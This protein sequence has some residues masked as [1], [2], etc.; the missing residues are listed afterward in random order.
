FI[1]ELLLTILQLKLKEETQINALSSLK[2]EI[3]TRWQVGLILRT[4]VES[5]TWRFRA[6]VKFH[7][8]SKEVDLALRLRTIEKV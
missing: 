1:K 8:K 4:S 7:W 3:D 5:P 2:L 6:T